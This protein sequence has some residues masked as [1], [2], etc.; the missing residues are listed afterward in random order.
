MS[1]DEAAARLWEL[2]GAL[3]QS[4]ELRLGAYN[5]SSRT[6]TPAGSMN[7]A[8][9]RH[10]A[11]PLPTGQVPVMWGAGTWKRLA[12]ARPVIRVGA[13]AV[14]P[15]VSGSGRSPRAC[16]RA[17]KPQGKRMNRPTWWLAL[18]NSC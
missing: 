12:Q 10:L 5:P 4:R 14:M 16:Q 6:W 1:R 7:V 3:G 13:A 18:H 17:R 8:R 11:A 15:D 2:A 9:C